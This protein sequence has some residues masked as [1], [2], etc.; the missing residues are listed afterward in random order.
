M[1]NA[2]GSSVMS[3][4][5]WAITVFIA[6]IPFIGFIMLFIWGFG[7]GTDPNKA[8]FAKGALLVILIFF[9]LYAIFFAVF[10]A[11]MFAGLAGA[12]S[13]GY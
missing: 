12:G 11:A 7:S 3:V 6:G 8:N 2:E 13:G 1:E 4:K 5:D 10:G 9:V